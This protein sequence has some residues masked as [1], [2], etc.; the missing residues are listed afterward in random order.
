MAQNDEDMRA[1]ASILREDIERF[2]DLPHD[3]LDSSLVTTDFEDFVRDHQLNA[4]RRNTQLSALSR[5]VS[6]VMLYARHL[7]HARHA[8]SLHQGTPLKLPLTNLAGYISRMLETTK[9]LIV[10]TEALNQRRDGEVTLGL[11]ALGGY[12]FMDFEGVESVFIPGR[13]LTGLAFQAGIAWAAGDAVAAY[14]LPAEFTLELSA[15]NVRWSTLE[16]VLP[17]A[18]R[19]FE[20]ANRITLEFLFIPIRLKNRWTVQARIRS[21]V[22][23]S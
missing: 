21:L 20:N 14:V 17:R 22:E 5:S 12:T 10:Y 8:A 18:I 2:A 4:R 9:L 19:V 23:A 13:P 6:T 7:L 15:G 16:Q 3:A 1:H 11:R